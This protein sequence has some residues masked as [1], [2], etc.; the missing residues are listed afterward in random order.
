[1]VASEMVV[2]AICCRH[3]RVKCEEWPLRVRIRARAGVSL[4]QGGRI[5]YMIRTP[6]QV[7]AISMG[8]QLGPKLVSGPVQH[9]HS[10]YML[11][12]R[13]KIKDL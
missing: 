5:A 7:L 4:R 9:L 13:A 10:L 12:D 11:C 8:F 1:M 6:P 2:F 3:S